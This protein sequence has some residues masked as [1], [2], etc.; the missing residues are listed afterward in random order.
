MVKL[1]EFIASS[2]IALKLTLQVWLFVFRWKKFHKENLE[3]ERIPRDRYYY[4][5]FI[6]TESGKFS[7][8]L[9]TVEKTSD[10]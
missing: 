4:D 7:I 6:L 1:K 3:G 9:H 2:K 10:L 5:T 8:S